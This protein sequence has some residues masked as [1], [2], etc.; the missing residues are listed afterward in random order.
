MEAARK[1]K[2]GNREAIMD[3]FDD[4]RR[5]AHVAGWRWTEGGATFNG[6]QPDFSQAKLREFI[7]GETE[8]SVFLKN[9]IDEEIGDA[10]DFLSE[11]ENDS[12]SA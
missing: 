4:D 11:A 7:T 3:R 5:I 10:S 2:R 9:F 12:A 6:E 8:F 1:G